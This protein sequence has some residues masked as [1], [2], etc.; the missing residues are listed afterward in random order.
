MNTLETTREQL[1]AVNEFFD[2]QQALSDRLVY[3][4]DEDGDRGE[5]DDSNQLAA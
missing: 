2:A 1:A 4:D 5:P 3:V